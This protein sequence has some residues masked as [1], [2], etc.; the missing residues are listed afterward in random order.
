[1]T[2]D[3]PWLYRV[4]GKRFGLWPAPET[5]ACSRRCDA[6]GAIIPSANDSSP[7]V[8]PTNGSRP[9]AQSM[10]GQRPA[11]VPLNGTPIDRGS[12]LRT[13]VNTT[14]VN[15]ARRRW[16]SAANQ[17]R[18]VCWREPPTTEQ[19]ERDRLNDETRFVPSSGP[20]WQG[21]H[22]RRPIPGART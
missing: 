4:N 3:T 9:G 6:L 18:V 13:A 10:N 20:H 17:P 12:T 2:N 16:E 1:M 22:S 14:P 8:A 15:G 21:R 5:P 19:L 7:V 11:A